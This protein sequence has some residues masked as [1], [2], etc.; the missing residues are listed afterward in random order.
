MASF[1]MNRTGPHNHMKKQINIKNSCKMQQNWLQQIGKGI[2]SLNK[3]ELLE[4]SQ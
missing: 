2:K 3:F 4:I 1:R